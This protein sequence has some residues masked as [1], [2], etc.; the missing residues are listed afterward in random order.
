MVVAVPM[1]LGLLRFEAEH[2]GLVESHV[3]VWLFLL[4]IIGIS[5]ASVYSFARSIDGAE[6][7][8]LRTASALETSETRYRA[9]AESAVEAIVSADSTGRIVFANAATQRTFGW[10]P[11]ELLG[12]ALT[13][14]MPERYREAHLA[15]LKRFAEGGPPSIIGQTLELVGLT[16]EGA[17]FPLEL[18]LSTWAN[19]DGPFFTGIMRDITGQKTAARL[20]AAKYRATQALSRFSLGRHALPAVLRELCEGLDFGLGIVWLENERADALELASS[21]ARSPDINERFRRLYSDRTFPPG[22][23]LPGFV[24][25]SGSAEWIEDCAADSRFVRHAL[26]DGVDLRSAIVVPMVVDDRCLGVVEFFGNRIERPATE[27]IETLEQVG[28]EVGLFAERRR[29]ERALAANRDLLQAILDNATA[30]ISVKDS[31]GR[32]LLANKAF[33]R[34]VDRAPE[35]SAREDRSGPRARGRGR[36][37]SGQ[38]PA[39]ARVRQDARAG[40]RIRSRRQHPDLPHRQVSAASMRAASPTACAPWPPTS[41]SASAPSSSWR[42]P[43]TR[44]SRPPG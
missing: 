28:T 13:V 17:E 24:W 33:A 12:E 11:E 8:R 19:E 1:V 23:G 4:A 41:P 16:R 2:F 29:T 10:S 43:A 32:F 6:A 30:L 36:P 22:K 39:R 42:G 5:V 9:L 37:G 3:S 44:R 20:S 21:W 31:E 7:R 15:G 25:E 38:R 18:S 35:E 14:L 26:I 27:L 34:L 40:E